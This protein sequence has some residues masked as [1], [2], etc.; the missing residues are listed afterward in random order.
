MIARAWLNAGQGGRVPSI[1]LG[2]L[3]KN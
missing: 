2:M 3:M 1:P